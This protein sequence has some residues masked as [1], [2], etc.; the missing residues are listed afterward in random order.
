MK[1]DIW[2]VHS[3]HGR[4]WFYSWALFD[5]VFLWSFC[6]LFHNQ[7]LLLL[8]AIWLFYYFLTMSWGKKFY[9]HGVTSSFLNG[10][11]QN[12]LCFPRA[13]KAKT[14]LCC[15]P[16]K[17]S[18]LRENYGIL[19]PTAFLCPWE[20]HLYHSSRTRGWDGGLLLSWF[21]HGVLDEGSSFWTSWLM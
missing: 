19:Y 11:N 2:Y 12:L 14:Y 15:I 21:T 7:L 4:Q 16:N 13:L 8:V 10:H 18:S 20:K 6:Y 3:Q 17:D 5:N 1:F 9:Y